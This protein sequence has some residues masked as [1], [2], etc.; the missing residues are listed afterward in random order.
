MLTMH[1]MSSDV[2]DLHEVGRSQ[3]AVVGGKGAHL[4]ELL[5]IQG[6]R[7]PPGFCI[8]TDA[9]R[10]IIAESPWSMS[11]STV[12]RAWA[13]TTGRRSAGFSAEVR[14]TI[15]RVIIPGDLAGPIATALV[16]LGDRGAYAVR[17][18]A[19]AEDSRRHLLRANTTRT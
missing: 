3:I 10:R 11:N 18:S 2:L 6:I 15:E 14:R 17:S 9:F 7:V 1:A 16:G 8:T 12:S 13:R 4:G 5:R 19:T